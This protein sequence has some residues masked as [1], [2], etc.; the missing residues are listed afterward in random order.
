M[1]HPG[2]FY[3]CLYMHRTLGSYLKKSTVY[4]ATR[5]LSLSMKE[6]AKGDVHGMQQ[7][8]AIKGDGVTYTWRC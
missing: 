2:G 7:C 8:A 4:D 3:T 6:T 1:A 5:S